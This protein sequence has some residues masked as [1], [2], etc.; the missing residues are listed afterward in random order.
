MNPIPCP[1][2]EQNT[3]LRVHESHGAFFANVESG[4]IPFTLDLCTSCGFV[5][6]SSAYQPGYQR[7]M[8]QAYSNYEVNKNFP[9]PDRSEKNS[10]PLSRILAQLDNQTNPSILEI[11]SNRGDLLFLLKEKLPGANILGVEPTAFQDLAVPTLHTHFRADLFSSHFDLIIMKHVLEHIPAPRTVVAELNRCLNPGGMLYIEVP[12][13][14]LSLQHGAEDFVPDHVSYFTPET[15]A[16]CLHPFAIIQ[17]DRSNFLSLVAVKGKTAKE[18]KINHPEKSVAAIRSGFSRFDAGKKRLSQ[19]IL[20][21]AQSGAPVIF[22][23]ISYYFSRLFKELADQ[24]LPKPVSFHFDDNFTGESEPTFGLPRRSPLDAGGEPEALVVL[25]S[26]NFLVQKKMAEHLAARG[27]QSRLLYP[28]SRSELSPA[29]SKNRAA[30]LWDVAD[31]AIDPL[32]QPEPL[33]NTETYLAE[34]RRALESSERCREN[35]EKYQKADK[36]AA[37]PDYLPIRIDIENVSRCNYRC[38]MCQVSEWPKG[39]RSRDMS[40]EEFKSLIDAQYGL[41]EIKLQGLGE[42]LLQGE[43]FFEMIRYARQR[44]IWVRVA[45]NA[46]LFHVRDNDKKLIDSGVNEVQ[47][48]IDGAD[49]ATFTAIR[50]GAVFERT[51][52]NCK[53]INTYC[54]EQGLLRTKMWTVVQKENRH[55]LPELVAFARETGFKKAVFSLNLVDFGLPEWAKRNSERSVES[56]FPESEMREIIQLGQQQGVDVTFWRQTKKYGWDHREERCPWPFERAYIA[57]DGRVVPCCVIGN[58]DVYEL[59]TVAEGVS[60]LWRGDAWRDFRQSHLDGPLPAICRN[61]YRPQQTE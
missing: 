59:G 24:G 58:P 30:R 31:E 50:R 36:R 35:Y 34:R 23:G 9:F 51:K 32:R 39:Q 5:Y 47:I 33:P 45:S 20:Q 3:I 28:W 4:A 27:C 44:H 46:S 57:S 42:P 43:P 15:L 29:S 54:A 13:L 25:C 10:A 41:V 16:N 48:S 40:L 7:L 1:L 11:G 60:D 6:Q 18:A 52:S 55:Q 2:C 49:A 8:E 61:C 12:D 21:H 56:L 26:N 14:E 38:V 22:Y 53:R 19:E 17:Q 37:V